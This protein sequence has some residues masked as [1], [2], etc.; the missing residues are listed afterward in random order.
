MSSSVGCVCPKK[1]VEVKEDYVDVASGSSSS[2]P[3]DIGELSSLGDEKVARARITSLPSDMVSSM[4]SRGKGRRKKMKGEFNLTL[5]NDA[6]VPWLKPMGSLRTYSVRQMLAPQAGPFSSTTLPTFY[7][8]SFNVN[9]LDNFASYAAVFDQYKIDMI[10]VLIN[11]DVT[12]VTT[13]SQAVGSYLSAVDYDDATVP[14]TL[15]QLGGY[16]S[17]QTSSG[18]VS[19]FHRWRPQF[20]VAAYSGTFTSYSASTGWIDCAYPNVQYYG[21]KIALT[22][23]TTVQNYSIDVT[24]HVSFR[25]TH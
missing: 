19:H 6:K 21:L 18:T 7:G 9:S 22:P 23:A 10:E 24:Y 1:C 20:A 8:L 12:E 13:G 17:C 16:A 2:S 3:K 11:P 15:A 5:G 25:A 14:T 4:Q